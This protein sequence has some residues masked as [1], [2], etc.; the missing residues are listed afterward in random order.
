MESIF[1][2]AVYVVIFV[3]IP[4]AKRLRTRAL[5]E[6]LCLACVNAVVTR[7]T[8]GKTLVACNFGG[9]MRPV[10]FEV[11]QCSGF[12][13]NAKPAK[14]VKIE[15]FVPEQGAVYAEVA[16]AKTPG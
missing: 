10:K 6:S 4:V 13:T 12:C 1:I 15:G 2:C 7:G 5:V 3:A 14:L 9:A 16:I 11:C 8:N